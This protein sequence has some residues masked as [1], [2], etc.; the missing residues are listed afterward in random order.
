MNRIYDV[1]T[2]PQNSTVKQKFDTRTA[3]FAL[4]FSRFAAFFL[5]LKNLGNNAI[6]SKVF[7]D[8]LGANMILQKYSEFLQKTG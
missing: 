8:G 5:R 7:G 2:P 6:F 1:Y 4:V 3:A